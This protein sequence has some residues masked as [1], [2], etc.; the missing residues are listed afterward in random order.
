MIHFHTATP[1][2]GDS[3]VQV[4]FMQAVAGEYGGGARVTGDFN[5]GVI[6]LLKEPGFSFDFDGSGDGADFVLD[7]SEAYREYARSG[8]ELHMAQCYF[9]M[10]GRPV[11][12]LPLPIGFTS[13]RNDLLPGLVI[14][15]FSYSDVGTKT[16]VWPHDRW[17]QV[18]REL[19]SEGLVDHAYVVGTSNDR[20][21]RPA[22]TD[23]S[24]RQM[25]QN[26]RK[27]QGDSME[28]DGY[29]KAGIRPVFDQPLPYVLALLRKASLVLTLDNGIGHLAHFGGVKRHAMLYA[30]WLPRRFAE[31]HWAVH[32][33]GFLPVDI[34]VD[35]MLLAA[36]Q[37]MRQA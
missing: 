6:P 1:L 27:A 28:I 25:I 13:V 19:L 34:S 2:I 29:E 9:R 18:A 14:S 16:K 35:Q 7:P 30:D 11:P 22:Q 24:P 31:S 26:H 32:V 37:A 33:R 17:I 5:K 3:L 20:M 12:D 4:P 21:V 15:P 10:F 36:R 23:G 8:H